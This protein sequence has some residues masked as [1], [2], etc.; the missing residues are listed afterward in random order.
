MLFDQIFTNFTNN[1]IKGRQIE[2]ST[3][4]ELNWGMTLRI[5]L[6]HFVKS[7]NILCLQAFINESITYPLGTYNQALLE[8]ENTPPKKRK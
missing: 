4:K 8:M 3:K 5:T 7:R 1:I 2:E 6:I